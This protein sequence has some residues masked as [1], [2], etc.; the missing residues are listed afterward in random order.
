MG[1]H[2]SSADSCLFCARCAAELHPGRGDFYIIRV[3]ALADPTPPDLSAEDLHRDHREQIER[4]VRAM[5]ELSER[6]LM[7]QV[8][9]RFTFHLC[10]TCY[11]DWVENPAG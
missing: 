6:E 7:D 11:R 3:E 5:R 2:E 9:R 10:G 4:L 1:D 8:Y